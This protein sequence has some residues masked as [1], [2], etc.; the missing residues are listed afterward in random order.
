MIK[1]DAHA[2][3]G[4]SLF[5]Q[6][7][8]P[9]T[10]LREMD[11]LDI[12]RAVLCPHLP[13]KYDLSLANRAV[14]AAVRD[15]PQR[16]YGWVRV[17]PWQGSCALAE[18]KRGIEE[19]GLNGLLLH[20]YEELFQISEHIVDLL[21]EYAQQKGLPVMIES[22]YALLSHPLDVAEL[23]GRFPQVR[24]IATH[25]LQMDDA[26]FALTDADLAMRECPNI[27]MESS[28]MYAPDNMLAVVDKL[29]LERL[30][31]GSHSPWMDLE[32]EVERIQRL[33]LDDRQKAAVFG[34]NILRV[35]GK[36]G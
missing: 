2:Y 32:F 30:L 19:Y 9:Q 4:D 20:P 3:V 22:G 5:G 17:D 14:A 21:L 16:F 1:I 7:R 33:A 31:F 10:L 11:R 8:T 6:S 29:G 23:A 36:A 12:E 18:L 13:P 27:V 34:G 25:G 28:G 35:L 26:G 24:I 15:H